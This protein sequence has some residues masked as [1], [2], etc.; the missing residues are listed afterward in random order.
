MEEGVHLRQSA[1]ACPIL[2]MGWTPPWQYGLA[3]RYD[4]ELTVSSEEEARALAEAARREGR[5][6]ATVDQNSEFG[7]M[8]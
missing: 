7:S 3:L 5:A 8:Y 6:A 4:L 1:I 2:V